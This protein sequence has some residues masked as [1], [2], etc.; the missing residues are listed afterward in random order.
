[1]QPS[2]LRDTTNY[3]VAMT[4]LHY[5]RRN[6]LFSLLFAASLLTG[7]AG[8]GRSTIQPSGGAVLINEVLAGVTGDNNTEFIELMNT[9]ATPLDLNEYSLWYRLPTSDEDLPVYQWKTKAFIPPHGHYLLVREGASVGM[10]PDA[11]FSQSLNLSS[12]GLALRN[13]DGAVVDSLGWGDPHHPF[14]EGTSA[15][16]LVNDQSL[17][18]KQTTESALPQ[19]KDNNQEDFAMTIEPN[20]ENV[21]SPITPFPESPLIIRVSGAE[22]VSPGEE[23]EY[24]LRVVNRTDTPYLALTIE[25]PIPEELELRQ[26][27]AGAL[28]QQD[29]LEWQIDKL[30]P[31]AEWSVKIPLR[32]SWSISEAVLRDFFV[33]SAEGAFA[34]GEALWI[35]SKGGVIPIRVARELIG[36]DVFVQGV[37]TMYTGGFYAGSS[38]TK[39]YIEDETGGVQVYVPGG[40]GVVDVPV[41]AQVKVQGLVELYRDSIEIIPSTP[42]QVEVLTQPEDLN[43]PQPTLVSIQQ[44]ANDYETLPGDLVQVEGT[45]ERLEEFN[46]SF[47]IDL[48]DREGHQITAYVDKLVGF[49][50]ES[51]G[52]GRDFRVNGIH[53]VRDGVLYLNPRSQVD[54]E[55][56]YPPELILEL[57][58][59]TSVQPGTEF[60][61]ELIASNHSPKLLQELRIDF[62]TD[63]EGAEYLTSSGAAIP[64]QG[65]VSFDLPDLR[66]DG[67]TASISLTLR[68]SQRPGRYFND[69]ISILADQWPRT[70]ASQPLQV[71]VGQGV[72]IWA[73]QGF[74]PTSPYTL[75][76]VITAGV[77][78]GMFPDLNGFFIQ[79]PS[80]DD[81]PETSD[82][83]FVRGAIPTELRVGDLVEVSGLVRESSGQTLIDLESPAQVTI[84]RKSVQLPAPIPL[85]PPQD[86]V[87]A[88]QYYEALEGMLVEVNE[89]ALAV[90]P[91]TRYGEFSMVLARHGI[92]RFYRGD[93]IGWMITADDGSEVVHYDRS[94]LPFV[95]T[96]GDQLSGLVGPLAYTFGQYKLE[97]TTTPELVHEPA[98]LPSSAKRDPGTFQI[99]TWNVENLF[100]ILDPHPADPPRPRKADYDLALTKVANT[101]VAGRFPEII[102]LQEVEHIGILEDLTDHG[103]L[104]DMGY[105]PILIEGTDSR[106]IDVAYLVRSD[107]VELVRV[108]QYPAPGGLTSRPPLLIEVRLP[109]LFDDRPI[110]ILNN[111]FTSLAGGEQAT[112]PR[113]TAQAAWNLEILQGLLAQDPEAYGVIL[114]DLNSFYS[115]A[116]IDLL[117][118]SGLHHIMEDMPEEGR[119]NYIFQGVSQT[120]DHILVTGNMVNSLE[121]VVIL[122]VNAD[123]PPMEPGDESPIRKSDHDP[124]IA[125]FHG[126]NR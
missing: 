116:P 119:Y 37:A 4:P 30:E 114:G 44:A 63:S 56:I 58:A 79:E 69:D 83:I 36:S 88:E 123:Y 110:F 3:N 65:K 26:R 76:E 93:E 104:R 126:G 2:S 31:E 38:G 62:P 124:V 100:D 71:F 84:A 113:R 73:I 43:D 95:V 118:D 86:G 15:P 111:H 117:R 7:C 9:G 24:E 18:R 32:A 112:E 20:P 47:E 68:A 10:I 51:I 25:L 107:Q 106:G 101:I 39:F 109:S 6:L 120:L 81:D 125:V 11:T 55:E 102:A 48:G 28:E 34:A 42:E 105:Q 5:R 78:T 60:A 64:N 77:V 41:G 94:Q 40:A 66:S 67:D 87:S 13:R 74:G 115:S 97:P 54:F 57:A 12:G 75:K 1:M 21:A 70:Y 90:S 45:V 98:P 61:V 82:G 22:Q 35:D 92:E 33:E 8:E 72:P 46:Y 17:L 122:H 27:P 121:D 91:T 49:N 23:L 85:D 50:P 103:L 16:A 53:E 89:P 52:E 29:R 99:M 96:T 19:D 59:P 80:G 14:T 108:E